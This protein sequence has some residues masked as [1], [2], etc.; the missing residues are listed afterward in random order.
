MNKA[1]LVGQA[2]DIENMADFLINK[3]GFKASD[4]QRFP[5]KENRLVFHYQGAG[6]QVKVRKR[7][8]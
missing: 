8:K 1:T 3:C 7:R 5:T 6:C 2:N 4:I